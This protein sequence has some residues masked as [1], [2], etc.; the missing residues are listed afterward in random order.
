MR[1]NFPTT[2]KAAKPQGFTKMFEECELPE[3]END[4]SM[5][6]GPEKD[7]STILNEESFNIDLLKNLQS[8]GKDVR[9]NKDK[10]FISTFDEDENDTSV[11]ESMRAQEE[12]EDE[13]YHAAIK[14]V[15]TETDSQI[16]KL[17]VKQ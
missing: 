4:I 12:Q 6:P 10:L 16:E 7:T 9:Q 3:N 15:W 17:Q 5:I 8:N 11:I 14:Q 2:S 1:N 13:A